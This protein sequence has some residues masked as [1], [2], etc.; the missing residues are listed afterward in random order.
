[1]NGLIK[2]TLKS[3]LSILLVTIFTFLSSLTAQADTEP[4]WDF[5]KWAETNRDPNSVTHTIIEQGSVGGTTSYLN[6]YAQNGGMILGYCEA[7]GKAP[8]DVASLKS[9]K[10]RVFAQTL[11]PKC[12]TSS[13]TNCFEELVAHTANG[14][15][16]TG[17]YIRATSGLTYASNSEMRFAQ[18]GTQLLY[19]L[20]G[21][22]HGGG[23]DTYAVEYFQART[24]NGDSTPRNLELKVS[25]VPYV[26]V[27]SDEA[28]TQKVSRGSKQG[29]ITLEPN[30]IKPGNIWMEDGQ[31]G[32]IANFA[33]LLDL[34]V[35]V[36]SSK[37]FGGWFR[38]RLEGPAISITSI[39][40]DQQRIKVRGSAVQVP[41]LA[42]KFT[43]EIW[44]KYISSPK[45]IFYRHK[46]QSFGGDASE[47]FGNFGT[48]EALR[49]VNQDKATAAHKVWM[50]ATVPA[51]KD[52]K[53]YQG[54]GVKGI[55][56]T[57]AAL[58]AGGA[59]TFEGGYLSYKVGGLHYLPGGELALGTYDL[60]IK[61]DVARCLYGFS[62]APLSA[63]ISVVGDQGDTVATTTFGE[64]NGWI[65]L[66]A[67]GFTFSTKS[68]KVKF[69]QDKETIVCISKSQPSKTKKVTAYAP[70]C[71]SG[72]VKK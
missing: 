16:V 50:F 4:Y 43:E 53:C 57:N 36:R 59:P 52:H 56:S 18:T 7:M 8:C 29:T 39:S 20:P 38:G 49:V 19:R 62:K 70:K 64:K 32:Q 1:M 46:G 6:Y 48:L 9:L 28:K 55:V 42:G 34:E 12:K 58:Y 23:S 67:N 22:I 54:L 45:E 2:K 44:D 14:D 65:R 33:E 37:E 31:F 51:F 72:Y 17:E 69:S 11:M 63:T 35:T 27:M 68:L 71:P 30:G 10:Y 5:A 3:F 15:K 26:E 66:S 41:R 61:S 60:L 21:I 24:Y 13:S 47:P 25:V 40:S